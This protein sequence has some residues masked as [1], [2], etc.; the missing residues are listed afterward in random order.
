MNINP[1]QLANQLEIP[2]VP[3]ANG[4]VGYFGYLNSLLD[5]AVKVAC[6]GVSTILKLSGLIFLVGGAIQFT[7][8]MLNGLAKS[9]LAIILQELI[10]SGAM[11]TVISGGVLIK[12][13]DGLSGKENVAWLLSTAL[14]CFPPQWN[15][16][17]LNPRPLVE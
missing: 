6:I 8:V 3:N 13:G 10:K 14:L 15:V 11:P 2:R 7:G 16:M 12:F 5:S 4:N 1:M 17:N 9:T